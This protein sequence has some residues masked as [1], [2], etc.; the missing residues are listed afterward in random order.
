MSQD[1]QSTPRATLA[2]ETLAALAGSLQGELLLPEMPAFESARKV[3]NGMIDRRPALIVRC[4]GAADVSRAVRFAREHHLLLAV[5]GGGHN[6]AGTGTCEGGLV[7]DLSLMKAV[8]VDSERRTACVEPGA[9]WKDFDDEAQKYGLA[10]TG[11]LISST[12]VAG[13]TLGGGIGWL[14]RKHGLACDNLLAADIVTA[15]GEQIRASADENADLLW[16]LRGGGGNFGVVTSFEFVLHPVAT[17]VGGMVGHPLARAG[18]VLRFYRDFVATAPDELTTIAVFATTPEGHQVIAIAACYAGSQEQG[19][20]AVKPLKTFGLPVIDMMGPLPYTVLQQSQ[21]PTAP[22]GMQHY[23]KAA[24][25]PELNDKVIDAIIE[26]A[27]QVTSPHSMIHLHHLGG[28][29]SRVPATATAFANRDSQF[30]VNI[31]G[32]WSEPGDDDRHINWTR[33]LFAALQPFTGGAY[34]NF[35]GDEGQ[36]RIRSA[37]GPNYER[38][39]ALK[40]Q[41]DP[42]NLFRLNQNIRPVP[43]C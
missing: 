12:G 9:T 21:D 17:V 39:L 15:T 2:R 5:R 29:M 37:Y 26:Y 19:E 22:A 34:I 6:V 10:T 27:T 13:F 16:G 11:G 31:I 40:N 1:M 7:I 42:T 23:W 14:V 28:T 24:F 38:L 18:E 36:E 41:Y 30:V 35:L 20:E 4:A 25:L 32:T 43:G 8:K 3:W 33:G